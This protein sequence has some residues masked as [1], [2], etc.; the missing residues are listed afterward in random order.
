MGSLLLDMLMAFG[1]T[2][3]RETR[4]PSSDLTGWVLVRTVAPPCARDSERQDTVDE[5]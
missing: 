4:E 3:A 2:T 1:P 5:R